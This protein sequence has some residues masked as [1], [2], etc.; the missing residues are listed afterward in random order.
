MVPPPRRSEKRGGG[1]ALTKGG[2]MSARH[3]MIDKPGHATAKQGRD[4][5]QGS[6]A[7]FDLTEIVSDLANVIFDVA[8]FSV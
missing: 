5:D 6:P 1:C 7:A 2:I 8:H 4:P 3:E